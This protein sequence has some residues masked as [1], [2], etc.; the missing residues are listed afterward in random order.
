MSLLLGWP[1]G[2]ARRKERVIERRAAL[3]AVSVVHYRLYTLE[4]STSNYHLYIF[5]STVDTWHVREGS[6]SFLQ[7]SAR[8]KIPVRTIPGNKS[9]S[10][11]CM[12]P[13]RADPQALRTTLLEGGEDDMGTTEEVQ[14]NFRTPPS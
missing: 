4:K 11:T 13:F 5:L 2:V 12:K 1:A 7:G 14:P 9:K 6:T 10:L 8:A 3:S